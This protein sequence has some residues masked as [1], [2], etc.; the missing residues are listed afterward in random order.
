MLIVARSHPII[1]DVAARTGVSTFRVCL[2]LQNSP[3]VSTTSRDAVRAATAGR[4]YRLNATA[5]QLVAH[6]TRTVGVFVLDPRNPMP[7]G[8]LE[9]WQFEVRRHEYQTVVVVGSED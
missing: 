8:T 3:R 4:G 6:R 9:G 5:Q 1:R 2:V 7:T